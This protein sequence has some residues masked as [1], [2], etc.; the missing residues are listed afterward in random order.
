[1]FLFCQEEEIKQR[2]DEFYEEMK[3]Q[4]QA[5]INTATSIAQLNWITEQVR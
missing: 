2:M 4:E 1:V 5:A 3:E